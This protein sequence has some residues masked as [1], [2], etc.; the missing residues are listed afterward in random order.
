MAQGQTK[1]TI[2]L[3]TS[4]TGQE[5]RITGPRNPASERPLENQMIISLSRYMRASVDTMAMNKASVRMVCV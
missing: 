5:K 1:K 2:T 3:I 4:N